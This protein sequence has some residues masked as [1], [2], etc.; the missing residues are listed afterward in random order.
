ML[1]LSDTIALDIDLYAWMSASGRFERIKANGSREWISATCPFHDDSHPSFA[2]NVE[3]GVYKCQAC[4][5][6][7]DFVKLVQHVERHATRFDAEQSLIARFARFSDD[8][9]E[10]LMLDLSDGRKE[11]TFVK[12]D[13][14][15]LDLAGGEYLR[16]RGLTDDTMRR[17]EVYASSDNIA[18]PWFDGEKR[19]VTLKYRSIVDKRFWY[20][21]PISAGRLKRLLYGFHLARE[22]KLIVVCEG[23]IDA[24]SVAQSCPKDIAAVAL[25]GASISDSQATLLKN[26]AADEILVF[27]D[28]D[29]AGRKARAAIVAK[30]VAHKRVSV[31]DWTI[32]YDDGTLTIGEDFKDANDILVGYGERLLRYVVEHRIP[33]G[34][35]LTFD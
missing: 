21:P 26:S 24:M 23:E 7:G 27:T 29:E 5:A 2:I 13:W 14:K 28:N 3:T 20:D 11:E 1:R 12:I 31:V 4:G 9:D 35:P 17:F 34:L 33:V 18:I 8:T 16:G 25:G 22:A 10:P 15:G 30:L 19:C 6:A 32:R